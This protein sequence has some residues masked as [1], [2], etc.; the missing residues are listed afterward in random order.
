MATR[1]LFKYVSLSDNE[2]LNTK[3]LSLLA[4]RKVWLSTFRALND[5]FEAK[6]IY[7]DKERIQENTGE[8]FLRV[9][10]MQNVL[11]YICD[12]YVVYS[13]TENSYDCMP[14]WAHYAS[15][16]KGFCIEFDVNEAFFSNQDRMCE[17]RKMEYKHE[18]KA[19]SCFVEELLAL[20]KHMKATGFSEPSIE[21][22][23]DIT[24]GM[25]QTQ[26]KN[27]FVKH[28]S[29]GYE[30]EWRFIYTAVA[31]GVFPHGDIDSIDKNLQRLQK[32]LDILQACGG[33]DVELCSIGL[34]ISRIYAG[35]TCNEDNATLLNRIS[36][37]LGCGNAYRIVGCSHNA[38]FQLLAEE[39]T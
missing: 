26:Y 33:I 19:I 16:H 35:M 6:A 36:N 20:Y 10:L 9:S 32:E 21:T 7:Y 24:N 8:S 1:K 15:N 5:P 17:L 12:K 34:S 38:K 23:R 25:M 4:M 27:F 28:Y 37:S 31:H 18:R 13:L 14:M 11:D 2:E 3:K 29:W 39:I 30:N 22:E